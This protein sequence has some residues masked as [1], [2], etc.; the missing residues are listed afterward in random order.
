[1]NDYCSR[2]CLHCGI[3]YSRITE[4][5][6]FT[7]Y[8]QFESRWPNLEQVSLKWSNLWG[9]ASSVIFTFCLKKKKKRAGNYINLTDS[10]FLH[11]RT[12]CSQHL[13]LVAGRFSVWFQFW[14]GHDVACSP[15]PCVVS[16]QSLKTC[17]LAW[18]EARNCFSLWSVVSFLCMAAGMNSSTPTTLMFNGKWMDLQTNWSYE[19]L[20]WGRLMSF[21]LFH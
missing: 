9:N 1:M 16:S 3:F 2:N 12:D 11:N 8:F 15:S 20:F 7:V 17:S 13:C 5:G 6:C 19:T 18:L 4:W 10:R 14:A 21:I